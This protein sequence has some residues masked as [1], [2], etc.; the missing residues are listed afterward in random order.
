MFTHTKRERGEHFKFS[1]FL[2]F[3]LS[4]F[5]SLSLTHTHT[6]SH[7]HTHAHTLTHSHTHTHNTHTRTLLYVRCLNMPYSTQMSHSTFSPCAFILFCENMNKTP[8]Q[9]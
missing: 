2:S 3:F 5:L 9:I 1:L 7:T 8:S 6:H 4:L